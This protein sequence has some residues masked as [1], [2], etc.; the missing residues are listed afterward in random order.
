MTALCT[1]SCPINTV[2]ARSTQRQ[3]DQNSDSLI[4]TLRN[5]AEGKSGLF[6]LGHEVIKDVVVGHCSL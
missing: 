4:S 5:T 2:T 3:P 1:C 6:E